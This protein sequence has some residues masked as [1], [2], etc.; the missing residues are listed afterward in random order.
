MATHCWWR[1]KRKRS[2]PDRA[3]A[4]P[5]F[6]DPELS[7]WQQYQDKVALVVTST[8]GQGD[9]PDSIAPL[10]H[11]IKDTLGFQPNLRYGVIALGDSSYPNFCNGGK[12]FDALLQEQS[13]QRVGGDVIH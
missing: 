3:T 13:A 9:L 1:K 11:G 5:C 6:E 8:T 2:S 10:F 4:R 12:Q 7:D